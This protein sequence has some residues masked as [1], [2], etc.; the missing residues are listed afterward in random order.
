MDVYT[1]TIMNHKRRSFTNIWQQGMR[2]WNEC[3]WSDGLTRSLLAYGFGEILL[4]IKGAAPD[5]TEAQQHEAVPLGTVHKLLPS[6]LNSNHGF[7]N[8]EAVL[9]DN[10]LLNTVSKETS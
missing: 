9:C 7:S 1:D 2:F 6:K 5:V 3:V 10:R 8:G 4:L